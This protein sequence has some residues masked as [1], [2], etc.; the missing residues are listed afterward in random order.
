MYNVPVQ[1]WF[2]DIN[3]YGGPLGNLKWSEDDLLEFEACWKEVERK[4]LK[5]KYVVLD[6]IDLERYH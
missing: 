1:T 4:L 5:G 2:E 6:V 3:T